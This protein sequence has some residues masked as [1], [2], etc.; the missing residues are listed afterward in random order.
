MNFLALLII[1]I[2]EFDGKFRYYAYYF[3]YTVNVLSAVICLKER[4][5]KV[6]RRPRS[7]TGVPHAGK[8]QYNQEIS[9]ERK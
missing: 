4:R 3:N 8:T 1:D 7:V 2:L 5:E 6:R 9:V